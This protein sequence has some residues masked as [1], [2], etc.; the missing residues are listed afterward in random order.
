MNSAIFTKAKNILFQNPA[1]ILVFCISIILWLLFF[2]AY[3]SADSLV[4]YSQSLTGI[5]EDWHP[6]I[7]AI[8]LHYILLL[9][10]GISTITLIQTVFGCLGIYLLGKEI[11]IQKNISKEKSIWAPFYILLILLL[12]I[13]PLPF[14][15]MYFVK[16]TW[17]LIGLI[18]IGYIALRTTTIKDKS[19]KKY[20]YNYIILV[21]L[22]SLLCITR[23]NVI[24]LM[25]I[26][27][28][29][30][31]YNSKRLA[32]KS[33][34]IFPIILWCIL[35]LFIYVI[36]QKQLQIAFQIK[37]QY[38]ENQVM[39]LESVGVLV[40]DITKDRYIR[41]IKSNLTPN[42]KEVYSAGDVTSVMSWAG[43]EKTLNQQTF[44]IIDERIKKEYVELALHEPFTLL[45]VKWAGFFSMLKPSIYKYWFHVRLDDNQFGLVQNETFKK[46]RLGWQLLANNIHS[47]TLLSF[48]GAEHIVWLIINII[49]IIILIYKKQIHSMLFILLLIPLGYYLSYLLAA[50]GNDFRFMYPATLF[51]Q[52][53]SLSLLFSKNKILS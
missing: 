2:P 24:V 15:L 23:Y 48:I 40:N 8:I 21:L 3:M 35:P 17:I 32:K 31:L 33:E 16:D 38:P 1:L 10:G 6:P 4:Q 47:I 50:T 22:M 52:I 53:I 42:Y 36:T 46:A 30:L 29:L 44:S 41:Y 19:E 11:L 28:L 51:V 7:M 43:S 18:W 25:P 27:F 26:F 12:P 14:Y 20:V 5:Y 9:G 39:A 45:K 34:S 37:K 49:L 13:S